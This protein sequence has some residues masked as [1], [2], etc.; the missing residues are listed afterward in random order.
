MKGL[1]TRPNKIAIVC[2]GASADAFI[3]DAMTTERF[4]DPYDEIWTLN[5][6]MGAFK[7]DKVF[8]MD[9]LKWLEKKDREYGRLLKNCG[10]PLITSTVYP[11]YPNAVEYPYKEVEAFVGDDVFNVNTVSYMLAY[12]LMIGVSDISIYG[13]DFFYKDGN[14]AE[15]GGQAV[16]FLIGLSKQY[17]TT[18]RIPG[19]STLM[20]AHK[21]AQKQ[22]GG[23][24]RE[25]YGFHRKNEMN[26][27]PEVR[28][29]I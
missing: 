26:V 20:Y 21:V 23:F 3:R 17:K 15:A 27:K 25:P 4:R 28:N 5:R 14:T 2:M 19:T 13:A 18:I 22:G 6:G 9:D 7:A 8:C 16:T 1:E 29:V 12:A 10:I 11:D 24:G